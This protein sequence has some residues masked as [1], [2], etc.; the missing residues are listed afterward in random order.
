VEVV[1]WIRD[2]EVLLAIAVLPKYVT[3]MVAKENVIALF[4]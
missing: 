4:E 3:C 2:A 1:A